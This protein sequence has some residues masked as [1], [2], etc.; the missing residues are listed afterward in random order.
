MDVSQKCRASAKR[1]LLCLPLHG[2]GATGSALGFQAPQQYRKSML[3]A[4]KADATKLIKKNAEAVLRP[5]RNERRAAYGR[6][7]WSVT[8]GV[9]LV[10][11]C[12]W[13]AVVGI[14]WIVR[15]FLGIPMGRDIKIDGEK[16]RE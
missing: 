13:V 7:A 3:T 6:Y 4:V 1:G 16:N 5:I 15:G 12:S 9:L 10:L 11:V 2:D 14:G 8:K